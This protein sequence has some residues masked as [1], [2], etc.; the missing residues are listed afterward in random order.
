M[1]KVAHSAQEN[2]LPSGGTVNPSGGPKP[3]SVLEVHLMLL[4]LGAARRHTIELDVVPPQG[5]D[6]G[7]ANTRAHQYKG[8]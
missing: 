3:P 6:E 8:V 1:I 2:P 5:S 7:L 4:G